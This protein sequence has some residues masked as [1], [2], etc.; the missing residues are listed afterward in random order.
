[1]AG[2]NAGSAV[3]PGGHRGLYS[4]R[5]EPLGEFAGGQ[6]EAVI[7]DETAGRK[8]A[9]ARDVTGNR[10]DGLVLTAVAVDR[11]GIE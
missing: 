3:D 7:G 2:L 6:E 11:P 4:G 1:M 5:N 10:V 9:G 8:T